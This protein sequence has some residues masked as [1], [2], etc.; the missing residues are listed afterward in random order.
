MYIIIRV[1]PNDIIKKLIKNK[2]NL[3]IINIYEQI[4]KI[5]INKT[6]CILSSTYKESLLFYVLLYLSYKFI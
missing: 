4:I 2:I 6:S 3:I 5:S 1:N